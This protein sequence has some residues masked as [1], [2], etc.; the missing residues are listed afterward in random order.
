G[1][2]VNGRIAPL[3][4]PLRNGD[5]IEVLTSAQA[6]P[7][8]DWLAHVQTGRARQKIRQWIKQEEQERS[9]SLGREILAREVRRRR[10]D[11]PTA[12]Q[13]AQAAQKLGLGAAE[14]VETAIGR[15]DVQIG[16][17][18]NALYP[19][20]PPDDQQ[21]PKPTA[22][23]RVI[24]RLRLGRGIKIHGVE[25]LMVR[26]A[27]YCQP[28][29][30]DPVVG[31]VTQGRGISIHRNDCPNLMTLSGDDERPVEF[32]WRVADWETILLS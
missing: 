13:L 31:Y 1:A 8:R 11:P 12:E 30:G 32:D 7:S 24:E 23:G 19:E 4:R 21:S 9:V 25:G 14:Q 17:V 10:L 18:I 15:G 26:Y 5:T 2:R 16:Q 20:I 29:H 3:H 22:F 28:V 6:K 27:Q